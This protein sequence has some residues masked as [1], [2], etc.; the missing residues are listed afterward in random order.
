MTVRTFLAAPLAAI[1]STQAFAAPPLALYPEHIGAETARYYR[2]SAAVMLKTA[3]GAVEIRPMPVEKG[4]VALAIAVYNH[5]GRPANFGIENVT[6]VVDGLSVPVP[7]E[8]Q[9][10][11]E[12]QRKAR[13][14]R[15]GT[16]LFAGALAGVAST[17]HN[18]GTYYRHVGG[19]HGGYTQA[20]HWQ[21]D[22][23]GIVGATA[24]V[25]GGAMV[26]HGIDQK[27]DYTLDQLNSQILQ[28]TTV[29]PGSS[30]GGLVVVPMAKQQSYPAEIRIQL[31]FNGV[32]YPFAFRL[33]PS[34]MN[35]PPPFPAPAQ[36]E[37]M[38]VNPEQPPMTP[39][40]YPGGR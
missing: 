7:T 17:A 24:A 16:A 37:A 39:A 10:A 9:L 3:S 32:S 4:R 28:T 14:A 12:A 29:D 36:A 25:A 11:D 22:T 34:G 38:P 19:P 1:L 18:S 30:F 6:A 33:T 2:G 35:V 8:A 15:I 31:V 20:I 23:P 40:T 13:G 21:N 26:I 27:L 5:S